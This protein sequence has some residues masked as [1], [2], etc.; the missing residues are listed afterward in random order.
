M[1]LY[2]TQSSIL[3]SIHGVIAA[4]YRTQLHSITNGL[5]VTSNPRV[6]GSIPV[7]RTNSQFNAH[8]YFLEVPNFLP[9]VS[10]LYD[11]LVLAKVSA[12][13]KFFSIT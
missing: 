3:P 7:G 6:T 8:L 9:H 10:F 1:T 4:L 13:Q 11:C 5:V 2:S 12:R